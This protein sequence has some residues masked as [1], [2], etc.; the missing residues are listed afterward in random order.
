MIAEKPQHLAALE[1]ANEARLGRARLKEQINRGDTSAV[2]ALWD[3]TYP[4]MSIGELLRAQDRWAY[5]RMRK[6]C[7]LAGVSEIK[8][9]GSLTERQRGIIAEL[10][11]EC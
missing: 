10:L 8:R 6:F 4:N 5:A 9:I 7:A 3:N 1:R 11:E 2:D